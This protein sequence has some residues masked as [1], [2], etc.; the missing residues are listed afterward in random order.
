MKALG[1]RV[2][3][4]AVLNVLAVLLVAL[5]AGVAAALVAPLLGVGVGCVVLGV[6]CGALA[7]AVEA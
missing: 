5:G 4:V 6:G 2:Q 1:V 7:R 3:L